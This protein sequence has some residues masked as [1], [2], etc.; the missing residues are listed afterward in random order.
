MKSPQNPT[1]RKEG[2]VI[3]ELSDEI[4]VYDLNSNKAHCLN[5]TAAFI[6][7]A[8]N[9]KN[10]INEIVSNFE[11]QTG[12]K[13]A[14][15]VPPDLLSGDTRMA[16]VTPYTS[17]GRGRSDSAPP[18]QPLFGSPRMNRCRCP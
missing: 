6:W 11:K 18:S 2:L 8:C 7:K 14:N 5:L 9:G 16:L 1:A 15:L 10:S 13:I 3:Q 12:G 17:E 4:L